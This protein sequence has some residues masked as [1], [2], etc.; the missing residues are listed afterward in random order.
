[1]ALKPHEQRVVE[2]HDQLSHRIVK[3]YA[4]MGSEAFKELPAE[5]RLLLTA[6]LNVMMA[7]RDILVARIYTFETPETTAG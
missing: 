7:Y 4:F 5:S 2:E 6:Q 1:M 3:L